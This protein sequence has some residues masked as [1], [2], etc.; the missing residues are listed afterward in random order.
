M[1]I[2]FI[3]YFEIKNNDNNKNLFNFRMWAENCFV[4]NYKFHFQK[5]QN[6]FQNKKHDTFWNWNKILNIYILN[7]FLLLFKS[8]IL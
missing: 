2:F 1:T 3:L 6:V 4:L 7:A 8:Y 5:Q